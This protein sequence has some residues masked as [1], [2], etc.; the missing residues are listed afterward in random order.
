MNKT[1]IAKIK[2]RLSPDGR[3]PIRI[4]GW[5]VNNKKAVVSEISR[6]LMSLTQT[7]SEK[8]TQIFKRVLSGDI[9]KNL[10]VVHFPLT[11]VMDGETHKRLMQ[12]N[13]SALEDEDNVQ[14][15]VADIIENLKAD[16]NYLVL[17]MHDTYDTDFKKEHGDEGELET[18]ASGNVF[19][20][21]I[22]AVCPVKQGKYALAYDY[23]QNDFITREPDWVVNAPDTGFLF[24][25]F[26]DGGANISDALFY[27]RDTEGDYSDFLTAALNASSVQPA[28]E[29]RESF[30]SVL[31]DALE[32]ECS[33]DVVEQ[34]NE[35][36]VDRLEEQ[37]KDKESEPVRLGGNEIAAMLSQSG[38]SDDRVVAFKEK[39]EEEFGT[40]GDIPLAGIAENRPVEL[41]TQDISVKVSPKQAGLIET[42]VIDG[43]KYILIPADDGVT[44]NGIT[45][46]I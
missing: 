1:D 9:G 28:A 14:A 36:L 7:E 20:Y 12:M 15:F 8:Y 18:E 35:L 24:P 26:E 31:M 43:I 32:E 38:V 37:K 44:V 29:S 16:G 33:Y 19:Q 39:F 4:R 13:A 23:A 11:E 34:M 3:N 17:L 46:D 45:I 30:K 21:I 40:G 22:C 25:C 5:Y 10:S 41:K 27:A 2:K 6:S 42:R